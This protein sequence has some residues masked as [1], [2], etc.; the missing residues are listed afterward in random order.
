MVD[1]AWCNSYSLVNMG[2]A[3]EMV[4]LFK[5]LVSADDIEENK[6]ENF[7]VDSD[8]IISLSFKCIIDTCIW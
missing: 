3:V 5:V 7:F 1:L 8:L 4:Y 6:K 2:T